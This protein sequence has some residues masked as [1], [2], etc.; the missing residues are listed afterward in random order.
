MSKTE[1]KSITT[2]LNQLDELVDWFSSDEFSLDEALTKYE[3]ATK[4][5]GEI[6]QDLTELKNKVEVLADFTK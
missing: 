5:A 3:S 6:N 2:K 1:S 4:L